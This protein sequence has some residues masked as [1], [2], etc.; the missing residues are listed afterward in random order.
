[1]PD[2]ALTGTVNCVQVPF[3]SAVAG[4]VCVQLR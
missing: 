3:A 4:I 1:M 2:C